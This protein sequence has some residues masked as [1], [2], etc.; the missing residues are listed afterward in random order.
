[1]THCETN[2]ENLMSSAGNTYGFGCCLSNLFV[3]GD[4]IFMEAPTYHLFVKMVKD[5]K[6]EVKIKK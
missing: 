3:P 6:M 5:R 4:N 1:M 2:P